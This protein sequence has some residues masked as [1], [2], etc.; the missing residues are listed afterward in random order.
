MFLGL[1]LCSYLSGRRRFGLLRFPFKRRRSMLGREM[2]TRR[3]SP[4]LSILTVIAALPI[5]A[6]C[7]WLIEYVA[8][9]D[10]WT[11]S[12]VLLSLSP[13]LG[14]L[15]TKGTVAL[16][17][18]VREFG[19]SIRQWG[20]TISQTQEKAHYVAKLVAILVVSSLVCLSILIKAPKDLVASVPVW[21]QVLLVAGI[22]E[23]AVI[24][25]ALFISIILRLLIRSRLVD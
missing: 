12:W 24:F 10:S 25:A 19:V 13:L 5:A 20:T 8:V 7:V 15:M 2:N 23:G 22:V 11:L 17:D 1:F 16:E 3:F 18:F 14:P 4:L 9:V 6:L 21:K